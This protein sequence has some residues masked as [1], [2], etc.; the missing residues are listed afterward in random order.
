MTDD[1]EFEDPGEEDLS[2]CPYYQRI[3]GAT[4]IYG[5]WQ[6]PRCITDEPLYGWP[7]ERNMCRSCPGGPHDAADHDEKQHDPGVFTPLPEA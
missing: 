4:C 6:E 1:E 5:C 2:G 7:S 3:K